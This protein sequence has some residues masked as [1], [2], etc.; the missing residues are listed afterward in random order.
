[1]HSFKPGDLVFN[2]TPNYGITSYRQ[3]FVGMV[4]SVRKHSE[5]DESIHV[6]PVY[7]NSRKSI[8]HHYFYKAD[9]TMEQY[10]FFHQEIFPA[11]E[12]ILKSKDTRKIERTARFLE[13]RNSPPVF[14]VNSQYFTLLTWEN[15][16]ESFDLMKAQQ[17]EHSH[18]TDHEEFYSDYDSI[19]KEYMEFVRFFLSQSVHIPQKGLP[20]PV[21]K[22]ISW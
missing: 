13:Q 9:K 19:R 3:F 5:E 15:F 18:F 21:I 6:I 22:P 14:H 7:V 4:T 17:L 11:F 12:L 8:A 20:L 1:M 2:L 16:P 10:H